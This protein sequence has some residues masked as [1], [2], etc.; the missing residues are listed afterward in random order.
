MANVI[1][2]MQVMAN[3]EDTSKNKKVGPMWS[4]S[5]IQRS[6]YVEGQDERKV[7]DLF[8]IDVLAQPRPKLETY[9]YSMPGEEFVPQTELII[10]DVATKKRVNVDTKKWK[11]QTINV[12]WSSQ[13][14]ADKLILIRK[15]RPLKNL[16]VCLV[17]AETGLLSVLFSEETW[18]YFNNEYTRLS[19]L[20][21]GDDIIWWSERTGWGQLYLYDGKGNLKNQITNGYFVTG[22]VERIDTLGRMVYFEAFGREE[23]VHPYY[24]MKY[25]ASIDKGG[26]T[27]ITKEPANHSFSMSKSNKYF[28]DTYSAVDKNPEAVLAIIT[29][30]LF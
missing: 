5:R 1:T 2:V 28:V 17:N 19:V 13:K 23:G 15:D 24:S 6:L 9:R 10:F 18:P 21:E 11:D 12:D 27:L 16:D 8:V 20:N 7:K 3:S 4:G 22:R 30:T 29:G 14:T 25:K 26:M